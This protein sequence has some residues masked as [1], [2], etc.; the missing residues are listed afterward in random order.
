MDDGL[1]QRLIGAVVLVAIGVI[2]IP[3]L[4][5]GRREV[6]LATQVPPEPVVMPRP[7]NVP[8]PVKP[9]NIPAPK[10]NAENYVHPIA[11]EPS[12][13]VN[14]ETEVDLGDELVK[15]AEKEEVTVS[16]FNE[17]GIPYAWTIQVSSF[18]SEKNATAF[19]QKLIDAGYKAYIQSSTVNG[20]TVHRVFVGPKINRQTALAAKSEIDKAYKTQALLVEFKP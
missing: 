17:E 7:L 15:A 4:L 14:T 20:N 1:K 6:D 10:S 2:F 3:S 9:E 13:D 19:K 16:G 5:N 11:D 8:E 12:P 18:G